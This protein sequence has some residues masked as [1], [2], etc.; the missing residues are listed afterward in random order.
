MEWQTSSSAVALWDTQH[1]IDGSYE[2]RYLF[3]EAMPQA[4]I[5]PKQKRMFAVPLA[6]R[7]LTTQI[8]FGLMVN[9]TVAHSRN[10][11]FRACEKTTPWPSWSSKPLNRLHVYLYT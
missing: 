9:M 1:D 7:S 4:L 3:L 5:A 2:S 10:T 11:G 8:C 6:A